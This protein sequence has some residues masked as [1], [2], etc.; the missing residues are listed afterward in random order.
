MIATDC[1]YG[2][3]SRCTIWTGYI[4]RFA[5]YD[6]IHDKKCKCNIFLCDLRYHACR[7]CKQAESWQNQDSIMGRYTI[8]AIVITEIEPHLRQGKLDET[9]GNGPRCDSCYCD[10]RYHPF[11]NQG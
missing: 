1:I 8:V 11:F 7:P 10:L 5:V 2:L 6:I 3:I 4:K 9:E